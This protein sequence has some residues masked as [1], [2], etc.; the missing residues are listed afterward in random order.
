MYRGKL[1][2]RQTL[3]KRLSKETQLNERMIKSSGRV[4][5]EKEKMKK[6]L[7]RNE[8]ELAIL[9]GNLGAKNRFI[10]VLEKKVGVKPR[11]ETQLWQA[12]SQEKISTSI[13]DVIEDLA[14]IKAK[15]MKSFEKLVR[16]K[17]SVLLG[18]RML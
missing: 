10:T 4:C 12:K 15:R 9:K 11:R 6:E 16:T 13:G 1:L 5:V 17:N 7:E 8:R 14:Q 3:G 2:E 18:A